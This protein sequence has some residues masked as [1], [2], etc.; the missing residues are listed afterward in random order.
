MRSY[1][2]YL[3]AT[4]ML[5]AINY[6][7]LAIEANSSLKKLNTGAVT[8]A[9]LDLGF[10]FIFLV[11]LAFLIY[12]N[13]FLWQQRSRE[14]GL[15]SMLGITSHNLQLLTIIEKC[16]LMV[17]SLVAGLAFGMIFE[18]LAFLGFGYLLN[19]G[20]ISQPWFVSSA[21]TK[22]IILTGCLFAIIMVI[23]LVK[24][25]RLTPNQLW[26]PEAVTPKR[27][28]ILYSI[29]GI[30]GFALLIWAYYIT[31]TIKPKISAI[32]HFLLAVILLV[33]GTYLVFIIGSI[34]LL[35]LLQK[36]S[37]FYYKP[38]HFIAVSGM[39]QRMQQ[40]GASLATIC[41]LCSSI[42]V[43]L[44]TSI[45]LYVGIGSTVKSYAPEDVVIT[46]NQ[47]LTKEQKRVINTSARQ[48]H[49][50]INHYLTYKMTTPQYGYWRDNKF[51]SQGSIQ[52]MDSKASSSVILLTTNEYNRITNQHVHLTGNE[53]L[54]YTNNKGHDGTLIVNNQKYHARKL[55]H[56]SGYFNP[57]HSIYTPTFIIA[58][59]LPKSLPL[60]TVTTFNYQ[61]SGNQ[62]Q[63]IKFE[64]A[65]QAKLG[66]NNLS[67]TGK[68]TI[69][70]LI[71]SL[72]GG[73]VFVG[74]LI[75]LAL[76]ITTTIVI[77]FKQISEG[78]A[79]RKRFKTMQQ[80]GLS[81]KETVKSIHSQVLMVFLLPVV[82][83]IVN[84]CF[85]IPA[86]RQIMIQLNFYNLPLMIT[87]GIIV[88]ISLLI[89]YL[90]L[91]GLTTRTYRQIV[92]GQVEEN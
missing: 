21:I 31:L 90:I 27:H 17:I 42:L 24:L 78:Y 76:A 79:D 91:Y 60:T 22:T 82:G 10:K 13:R 57:D 33:I 41:L 61:L 15:Y 44:F 54:T 34:I 7:F 9:M 39:I 71:N 46:S 28:G 67:F 87:V 47:G 63:R 83:A 62:K 52:K 23:D 53:A 56:F 51:I 89:L 4:I 30:L 73:L 26:H 37:H 88:A 77:Y 55:Q 25:H 18:K 69:T 66:I 19:I 2:P 8:S 5:V 80:V 6:I 16:Y 81:E 36:N 84:L 48:H 29:A 50:K 86:I 1:G 72:Y 49:A 65:L 85:A 68:A 32:S 20:H 58:N 14:I 12:V 3:M 74:I 59:K 40:N 38:R 92:D 43:I 70:S 75:S 64:N 45:T 11:T 35:K